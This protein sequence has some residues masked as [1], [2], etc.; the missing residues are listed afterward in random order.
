MGR[1]PKD[2]NGKFNYSHG[3][4]EETWKV[5]FIVTIIFSGTLP[6]WIIS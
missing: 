5:G 4:I 3:T 6:C 2:D 1:F